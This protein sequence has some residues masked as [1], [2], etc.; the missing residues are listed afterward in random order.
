MNQF[1]LLSLRQSTRIFFSVVL[2]SL[3]ILLAQE[4]KTT[5][6]VVLVNPQVNFYSIGFNKSLNTY[7]WEGNAIYSNT[8]GPL[9]LQFNEHFRSNLIRT[10]RKL[11][12]D[13][14]SLEMS[15]K[16]RLINTL[17]GSARI[18][19]FI[20]SDNKS[21]GISNAS[22]HG[23]Y[24]GFEYTPV[25]QIHI[26]P[27]VGMKIDNQV[28]QKDRGISYL[29][30]LA[31]DTLDFDGYATNLRG[32]IQYDQI[33]P[34]THEMRNIALSVKRDFFKQTRNTA[35]FQYNRSRREFYF[36]S[37]SSTRT[38][39][40]ITHNIESRIEDAFAFIDSLN[41]NLSER[42]LLEF[43]GNIFARDI[44]REIRH[45]TFS[46][47]R[48]PLLNTVINEIKIEGS[49]Q[50]IYTTG[51]DFTSSLRFSYQE[52]EEK[53]RIQPE[54]AI[55]QFT[56]DSLGRLEERKNSH[57]RRTSLM[58]QTVIGLYNS[59][60]ITISGSGSLLRYDTPST[61]NDDDRDELWY[62]LNARTW[63]RI[64]QHL[65]L[66]V[67]ADINLTHLVYL[68]SSRSADNTWNRIF[69]LSPK[70]EYIPSDDFTTT[71][72][73]EVLANYT[74]Y[75]FEYPGSPIRSFAFRQFAFSDS[76]SLDLSDRITLEWFSHIRLYERGDLLWTSFSERPVNYFED[77]TYLSSLRYRMSDGLLFSIGI[78]YFSQARFKY[79]GSD[80]SLESYL[81]RIG[82]T[83]EI[84][85]NPVNHSSLTMRGWY[86]HQ[87]QTS[88]TSRRYAHM[89]FSMMV[90]I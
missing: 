68:L 1:Y 60:R 48:R 11:I 87:S 40:N 31:F 52:R 80:R 19:S 38:I 33:A 54:E 79:T 62:V 17:S 6:D 21:I 23:V 85:W 59:H 69:R 82:P 20:L 22:S 47:I 16:H 58:S 90:Q 44:S 25:K 39:Y 55:P 57:T 29:L 46:D 74:V 18:S 27:L 32:K 89:T 51:S 81:R 73:F 34:R 78:R 86:E 84:L 70:L 83:V 75:D 63:H 64:N 65:N 13:E 36:P 15:L 67:A 45:R 56:I 76:S 2:L 5:Q 14:Q 50:A 24:G 88:I 3:K 26:E 42:A 77:K 41:Y 35:Q 43:Q 72:T 37:D 71:N 10:D 12:T 7:H 28:D 61:T 4:Y 30:G 53:H 66:Q 9:D 8:F 49:T